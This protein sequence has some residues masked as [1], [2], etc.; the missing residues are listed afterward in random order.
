MHMGRLDGKKARAEAEDSHVVASLGEHPQLRSVPDNN[1]PNLL[2][3]PF[4]FVFHAAGQ[5]LDLLRL[6]DDVE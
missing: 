6:L 2:V 5:F 1:A 4:H 3:R